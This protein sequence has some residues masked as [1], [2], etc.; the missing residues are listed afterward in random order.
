MMQ[1]ALLLAGAVC[2]AACA[3]VAATPTYTALELG[4][5]K[6]ASTSSTEP[7][8]F[9][10]ELTNVSRVVVAIT[11]YG[12]A[13]PDVFAAT[14]ANVD[15]AN[16][17][18]ASASANFEVLEI[19]PYPTDL[20]ACPTQA[21]QTCT[22][23][24]MV[25]STHTG[26][27]L[28]DILVTQH[29]GAP[30]RL[31]DGQRQRGAVSRLDNEQYDIVVPATGFEHAEL[32]L[33][34]LTG[35]VDL[36]VT[37]DG[38][39]PTLHN[40]QYWSATGAM[41]DYVFI[42][43]GD[44][45]WKKYCAGK[46]T[47]QI[48]IAVT[49]YAQDSTYELIAA[50]ADT[51][52]ALGPGVPIQDHVFSGEY[53][54]FVYN[55]TVPGARVII[56]M[57]PYSGDPDILV[58]RERLPVASDPTSYFAQ[59]RWAGRDVLQFESGDVGY[60]SAPCKYVIGVTGYLSNCSFAIVAYEMSPDTDVVLPNGQ[61]LLGYVAEHETLALRYNIPAY[62]RTSLVRVDAQWGDPDLFVNLGPNAHTPLPNTPVDY[63]SVTSNGRDLV[64]IQASDA[65]F[66]RSCNTSRGCVAKL[67]VWG[68]AE[69]VFYVGA[70]SSE[71]ELLVPGQSVQD[72][73]EPGKFM[74]F[75]LRHTNPSSEVD[76]LL[77]A[78]SGDADL[79]VGTN[80]S[81]LPTMHSNYIAR[82]A[83]VGNDAIVI[84]PA[85]S[86]ACAGANCYYVIGVTAAAIPATFSLVA[87]ERQFN[88]P[89]LEYGIPQQRTLNR[90]M[91]QYYQMVVRPATFG[92]GTVRLV[93]QWGDPD[94]CIKF[95]DL[96]GS[97]TDCDYKAQ[98]S[99]GPDI[100]TW[101]STD[102]K[103]KAGCSGQ[104]L[105]E[106][107]IL[108]RAFSDTQYSIV[109]S[110]NGSTQRLQDGVP[111]RGTANA[112][113][114]L[115]QFMF[116]VN[117][118]NDDITFS[119]TV[120]SGNAQMFVTSS[121][122]GAI[123]A[124]TS[125]PWRTHGGSFQTLLLD[126]SDAK[127]AGCHL[128]GSQQG[129]MYYIGVQ[130]L[131][132][133]EASYTLSASTGLTMLASGEPV[134]GHVAAASWAYYYFTPSPGV[135]NFTVSGT[136]STGSVILFIGNDV[137][138]GTDPS[139]PHNLILPKT[140]CIDIKCT[141]YQVSNV[142][143]SSQQFAGLT[144]SIDQSNPYWR[145]GEP[146]VIGVLS[147]P[148][149]TT[150]ATFTITATEGGF[151][152]VQLPDGVPVAGSV[153]FLDW[154]YYVFTAHQREY[155][156]EFTLTPQVGDPDL[157]ATLDPDVTKVDQYNAQYA[158]RQGSASND[159]FIVPA[160]AIGECMDAWALRGRPNTCLIRLGVQGYSLAASVFTLV[161]Q[162]NSAGAQTL[163]PQE[164]TVVST[165][166]QGSTKYFYAMVDLPH[167]TEFSLSVT[168]HSGSRVELYINTVTDALPKAGAADLTV[169]GYGSLVASFKPGNAWY[170]PSTTMRIGVAGLGAGGNTFDI[171]WGADNSTIALRD[172]VLATAAIPA[173]RTVY[174]SFNVPS[175]ADGY[176]LAIMPE[177]S[178]GYKWYA[179]P[180]ATAGAGLPGPDNFGLS[181]DS[182]GTG[183]VV[184]LRHGQQHF[185]PGV[186]MVIALIAD[187]GDAR[188]SVLVHL[189]DTLVSLPDGTAV[190][191]VTS[192]TSNECFLFFCG[193]S[194]ATSTNLQFYAT[195]TS[196]LG[197]DVLVSAFA[198]G[199]PAA[200][201]WP[202]ASSATWSS[203][204][205]SDGPGPGNVIIDLQSSSVHNRDQP[206]FVACVQ[207]H[208]SSSSAAFTL[209]ASTDSRPVTLTP[210]VTTAQ[211]SV[212]AWLTKP[213]LLQVSDLTQ[214]VTLALTVLSGQ[215]DLLLAR[216][217][218]P[219]CVAKS[220]QR[221]CN[222]IWSTG[223]GGLSGVLNVPAANPCAIAINETGCNANHEWA[224]GQFHVGV[225]AD[226]GTTF[227]LTAFLSGVNT[228]TNGD[229]ALGL[230]SAA[231]PA[232]FAFGT[233]GATS[234][235]MPD[236]HLSLNRLSNTGQLSGSGPTLTV[237]I[238]VCVEEF[239][240]TGDD[241]PG[242]AHFVTNGVFS[243]TTAASTDFFITPADHFYCYGNPDGSPCR[244]YFGVYASCDSGVPA[245]QC[246]SQ[247]SLT[248]VLQSAGSV[249]TVQFGDMNKQ[250]ATLA[251]TASGPTT[252]AFELFQAPS[253]SNGYARVQLEAC[254]PAMPALWMCNPKPPAGTAAC[255]DAFQP[256][257]ADH[258]N[259]APAQAT[260]R[261]AVDFYGLTA[262]ALYASVEALAPDAGAEDTR[263][264]GQARTAHGRSLRTFSGSGGTQW[265]FN[266]HAS[267]GDTWWL[268]PCAS[269][270]SI[271]VK[272]QTT[273]VSWSAPCLVQYTSDSSAR[274]K[275]IPAHALEYT[276][277]VAPGTFSSS[278][279]G[280]PG[281]GC[282]TD[283]KC[284]GVQPLT[285]CGL[286]RWAG[287]M[288]SG[289][290]DA[291][292]TVTVEVA[293]VTT[294]DIS[295]LVSRGQDFEVNVVAKCGVACWVTS[296]EQSGLSAVGATQTAQRIAFQPTGGQAA[297]RPS[298]G[299]PPAATATIVI[300]TSGIVLA[301]LAVGVWRYR[302]RAAAQEQY[303]SLGDFSALASPGVAGAEAE[304]TPRTGGLSRVTR[305]FGR[306]S[307]GGGGGGS[308]SAG[309]ARGSGGEAEMG[310]LASDAD[311][312]YEPPQH[313]PKDDR[314]SEALAS[315][316]D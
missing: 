242:P 295:G 228:L 310:L 257:A 73:V 264:A 148:Y 303:T 199:T 313:R 250:V 251:G 105:C 289:A 227:T 144:V 308:G 241:H 276:V 145:A 173:G 134:S 196:G 265:E 31:T 82:S 258:T 292:G 119:L 252:L 170:S 131:G 159:S 149:A 193:E 99:T 107:G 162:T 57:T 45:P 270:V 311:G 160:S 146:Y 64:T 232:F 26:A 153:P 1:R 262:S 282:G 152:V 83:R 243:L 306:R 51:P 233:S 115:S 70:A 236:I 280:L 56:S 147:T 91:T 238:M 212:E 239:C 279:N 47:C 85:T 80:V 205:G 245:A 187:S 179:V 112:A 133:S 8:Y 222:T 36:L 172:G 129:C 261:F 68:F 176:T 203:L 2:A 117:S 75:V 29:G 101:L 271:S 221:Y 300:G 60:C 294:A 13:D 161:G 87:G 84:T 150:D 66:Q 17:T 106:V 234:Q 15:W 190:A 50:T 76:I 21:G 110:V 304:P 254:G 195:P 274:P 42:H 23:Y 171:S 302:S 136:A 139:N 81:A 34:T 237:Y 88:A 62:Q 49:G 79:A 138:T 72:T 246:Q 220:G 55:A 44:G 48:R 198:S 309:R 20:H 263:V 253:V 166:A 143:L 103:F 273:S 38:T 5:V 248:A 140:Q 109:A 207:P 208:D 182:S 315:Y 111:V 215:A 135:D 39:E 181:G 127:V 284:A 40:A 46:A 214:D 240:K 7:Q 266:L 30:I 77:T 286:D 186:E 156:V 63:S 14:D 174:Y 201:T 9:S 16:P 192:A 97:F 124:N 177:T 132:N 194:C 37:L 272:E 141:R 118:P 94:L 283:V 314:F 92:K 299:L 3:A 108:V 43:P 33:T 35:D 178:A 180:R 89:T 189:D 32:L 169:S 165:V 224:T 4:Q 197:V 74:Y 278:A 142:L 312:S 296:L 235:D 61:M 78:L 167:A 151:G 93:P 231:A 54:Y 95:G 244:Y 28:F 301:L 168:P 267:A 210:G 209:L 277:Y 185:V 126:A 100:V 22:L 58:G 175:T 164:V 223:D 268:E 281:S 202:T 287:I 27:D 247:F 154:Q 24:I 128:L 218:S 59:S 123:V 260:G 211:Y 307:G 102:T 116:G 204:S 275:S 65:A 183:D 19:S 255:K 130:S 226:I 41:Q 113:G 293:N 67:G 120:L 104:S 249:K 52:I 155:D 297:G 11:P 216:T 71:M 25:N 269:S 10:V 12:Y 53:D 121:K 291:S 158:S 290:E 225:Y 18:W 163:L 188:A 90:S 256:S 298:H 285:P 229:P 259:G 6:G 69:S 213:F 219:S 184:H 114:D 316:L 217:F 96:P 98:G 288:Q 137:V 122:Y 200:S 206:Y 230:S 305:L 86:G 157:F 125:A 191:G